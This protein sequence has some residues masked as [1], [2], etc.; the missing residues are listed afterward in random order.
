MELTDWQTKA[1]EKVQNFQILLDEL[2]TRE[3]TSRDLAILFLIALLCGALIKTIVNDS[4]TIGFDDYKLSRNKNIVDLNVLEKK[5]I[6]D[7]GTVA[8]AGAVTPRGE[9]C[10]EET[11]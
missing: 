9:T 1:K 3:Y 6:T 5:L 10:S 8:T 7:G 11:R 4:L 2:L